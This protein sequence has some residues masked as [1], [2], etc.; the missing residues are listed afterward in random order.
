[1]VRKALHDASK[2]RLHA[3]P[4]L[5]ASAHRQDRTQRPQQRA[6]GPDLLPAYAA[7]AQGCVALLAVQGCVALPAVRLQQRQQCGEE[8]PHQH[9]VNN[10]C[11]G[12]RSDWVVLGART[13]QKW[14]RSDVKHST[15][16]IT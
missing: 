10:P 14:K 1:M 5:I 9:A 7:H 6:R 2:R 13:C 11:T 3:A 8:R 4:T 16:H 15:T 12:Y